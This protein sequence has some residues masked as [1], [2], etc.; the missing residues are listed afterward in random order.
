M[1]QSALCKFVKIKF[2]ESMVNEIS[3]RRFDFAVGKFAFLMAR[4]YIAVVC[5]FVTD[6]HTVVRYGEALA[7]VS[8][9]IAI[10]CEI[11]YRIHRLPTRLYHAI[12][13]VN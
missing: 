11:L 4:L 12:T 13:T 6:K 8:Y 3:W 2:L 5:N 7:I 1:A 10:F 9:R